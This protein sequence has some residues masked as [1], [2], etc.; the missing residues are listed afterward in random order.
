[1]SG[2]P[3][4]YYRP[5]DLSEVDKLLQAGDAVPLGGGTKLLAGA[6]PEAVVDLQALGLDEIDARPDALVVGA[7]VR[8]Q[9][10]SDFLGEHGR[11]HDPSALLRRA[12]RQ[13]GPNTYRNAATVGGTVASRLPDSELLA[14]LLALDAVVHIHGAGAGPLA[15]YLAQPAGLITAVT[16]PWQ[17]GD[18][19]SSRVAR[20]PA[21][22]PIVSI[23]AWLPAA[24]SPRL[25]ATGV[26]ALP[27]RL[28]TAESAL[29]GGLTAD[30]IAAAAETA[31]QA[32]DH[33][34]DFRGDAGYRAE[35]AA[36]LTRRTLS[37]LLP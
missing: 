12:L 34:G 31:Q 13:A 25:A 21:D 30:T 8:L 15:D 20:T 14:A 35:M 26:S 11:D 2:Q 6:A 4:V 3:K 28:P 1:M 33:P 24:G 10:L 37:G 7:T 19:D 36:V 32:A 18:G 22:D 5:E 27:Q 16:I 17:S 23:T 29:A 9:A